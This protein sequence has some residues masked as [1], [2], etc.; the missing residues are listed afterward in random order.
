MQCNVY[1]TTSKHGVC[2]E[3]DHLTATRKHRSVSIRLTVDVAIIVCPGWSNVTGPLWHSQHFITIRD[4][5]TSHDAFQGT[6]LASA[7]CPWRD[8]SQG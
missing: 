6:D 8:V 3:P 2:C 1:G 4:S 5:C 7:S